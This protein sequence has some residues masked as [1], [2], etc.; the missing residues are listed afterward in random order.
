MTINHN[1]TEIYVPCTVGELYRC[2]N[3]EQDIFMLGHG[4]TTIA[5]ST[6]ELYLFH[7]VKAVAAIINKVGYL[8]KNTKHISI[9]I[10]RFFNCEN[11][12]EVKAK[13]KASEIHVIKFIDEDCT[14]AMRQAWLNTPI[15]SIPV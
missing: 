5:F 2:G 7:G 15:P 10:S 13:I 6:G 3:T 12:K 1:L 9:S 11:S 4:H 14:T 8:R